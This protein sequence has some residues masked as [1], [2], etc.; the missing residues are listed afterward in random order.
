MGSLFPSLHATCRT[1]RGRGV[2]SDSDGAAALCPDCGGAARAP[3]K[4]RRIP[5]DYLLPVISVPGGDIT[6]QEVDLQLD[7]DSYFEQVAWSLTA[8]PG[9][10]GGGGGPYGI[11]LSD[12]STG[13]QF[14]NRPIF[15][16]NFASTAL[17][18]WP[19]VSPYIWKPLA[20][21]QFALSYPEALGPAT[22]DS[23]QL[24]LKG[25]KLYSLDG[26]P[27]QVPA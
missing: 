20:H 2:V 27:L 10:P 16:A 6:P 9:Y 8:A 14:S 24:V 22:A 11:Q 26:S 23:L 4:V 1:C 7:D 3:M 15:S 13:W 5:Y 12:L 17:F 19:L 25:Y 21:V 18:P